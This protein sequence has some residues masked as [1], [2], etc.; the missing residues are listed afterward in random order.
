MAHT[1]IS[2]KMPP[3]IEPA[4]APIAFG[5]RAIPKL[6][7]ELASEDLVTRQ[8]ALTSLCDLVHDP[9]RAYETI[10]TGCLENLKR[11][12]RDEDSVVR[13]KTTEVL[14]ELSVH[15]V[16]RDAFLQNEVIL[17]LAELLDE[18]VAI[19]RVNMHKTLEMLSEFTPGAAGIVD[20][21]LVPQLVLKLPS[22]LVEIQEIILDTLHFCL[23]VNVSQ[24]LASGAIS[25]LKE[26]LLHD[27]VAIRSKAAQAL[28]GI[29]VPLEG[30]NEVCKQNIIPILVRLLK[31]KHP[32]VAA[33]AAGSLMIATIT[34]Q[35]KYA[36]L[37]ATAI[38]PL[39][40]LVSSPVTEVSLN[41]IKAITTLAE[42][43]EGRRELLK[44]V[45]VLES[46][47]NHSSEIIRR[48]AG[49]AVRV[50][51]WKP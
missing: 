9:E 11:L 22:E 7:E 16:G 12:L 17:S 5:R 49:T 6:N 29:C 4:R 47:Q 42:A 14:Y 46:K 15:N 39:L 41:A 25:I 50:I 35:G 44:H 10:E 13:R 45:T 26:K 32:E 34:T 20:A 8:C 28:M 19:C 23:R 31:D 18:P 2:N 38:P 1:R 21:G 37:K 48:A 30:K 33:K 51:T 43:P 40:Q 36:A 27:S 3:H 24:A